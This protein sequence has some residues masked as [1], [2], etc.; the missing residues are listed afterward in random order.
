MAIMRFSIVGGA[1]PARNDPGRRDR[2]NPEV[3]VADAKA[4]AKALGAELA[5]AVTLALGLAF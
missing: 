4:M 3:K 2:Y 5:I 1:D